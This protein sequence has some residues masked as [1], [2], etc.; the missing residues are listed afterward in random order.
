MALHRVAAAFVA[1]AGFGFCLNVFAAPDC[2]AMAKLA[3]PDVFI[4]S[5]QVVPAATPVPEYCKVLGTLEQTIQFEVA[6]P[7]TRWNGKL[8]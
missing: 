4:K 1:T 5:A 2:A 7:T 6:L 8:F 3:L